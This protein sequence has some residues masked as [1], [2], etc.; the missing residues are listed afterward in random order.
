MKHLDMSLTI[1]YN[2]ALGLIP[3]LIAMVVT[4]FLPHNQ[5]IYIGTL[6]NIL[7]S[8][9]ALNFLRQE[10]KQVIL[11]C[12]TA[13]MILMSLVHWI[14]LCGCPK[15]FCSFIIEIAV[16]LPAIL[17]LFFQRGLLQ[18]H[19][20]DAK[21]KHRYRITLEATLV[22]AKIITIVFVVQLIIVFVG[23]ML[24]DASKEGWRFW[25]FGIFP[26]VS[27][28]LTIILNQISIYLFNKI[29]L[30]AVVLPIVNA[31]GD[32][33]GKCL[34]GDSKK[35]YIHPLIRISVTQNGMEWLKKR[36]N[37]CAYDKGRWD[38]LIEGH[39][40]FKESLE[41]G[42]Y[43]MLREGFPE[44]PTDNLKFISRY[45]MEYDGFKRLVYLFS[46]DLEK[47]VIVKLPESYQAKPWTMNQIKTN[48]Q[49]N[50]FGH[51][52]EYEFENIE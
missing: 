32:V 45:Y 29:I 19:P 42:A 48:I 25:A 10:P 43:R 39:L 15:H 16:M 17:I 7:A 47:E 1:N 28:V 13:M 49:K 33:I 36:S 51:Y 52:F 12:A 27:I 31:R 34:S 26:C 20:T 11:F 46:L 35:K 3:S 14:S 5:A 21:N 6:I 41:Q 8:W 2:L 23:W 4:F 38:V 9:Y 37:K 44:F 18:N 24:V 22:S 40:F 50:V 30:K